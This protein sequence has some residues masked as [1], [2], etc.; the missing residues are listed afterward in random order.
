MNLGFGD[1]NSYFKPTSRREILQSH[2]TASA[3]IQPL[4]AGYYKLVRVSFVELKVACPRD[5][6]D[7]ARCNLCNSIRTHPQIFSNG[8]LSFNLLLQFPLKMRAFEVD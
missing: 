1:Y 2:T 4:C 6:Q 7:H 5:S 8:I 3:V